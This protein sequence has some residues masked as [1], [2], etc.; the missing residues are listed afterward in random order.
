MPD[1]VNA[2]ANVRNSVCAVMRITALPQSNPGTPPQ[3]RVAFVGTAWCIV[4][5]RYFL[6]A[7]HV[8]NGGQPRNPNDKFSLFF[9]PNNGPLA[10]HAL[11]TGFSLEDIPNDMAILEVAS[12][13]ENVGNVPAV[14]VTFQNK[15]DGSYVFTYGFPS[16]IISAGN[17]DP[18]GNWLGGSLVLK[19]HANEGLVAGQYDSGGLIYELNVGWHHGESGGPIL[20][21]DPIAGFAIMQAYRP[22]QSP[23]GTY[24]GPHQGRSLVAIRTALQT[25]G[26]RVI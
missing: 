4:Q 3:F 22:I 15:P 6:T 19:G 9:V 2:I 5:N 23:G 21:A 1:L 12:I 13:P 7:H 26:A 16:P 18:N 10:F 25:L 17:V 20:C 24:P 11:V 14:P 8:L